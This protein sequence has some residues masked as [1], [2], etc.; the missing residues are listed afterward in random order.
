MRVVEEVRYLGVKSLQGTGQGVS[1]RQPKYPVHYGVLRMYFVRI[2]LVRCHTCPALTMHVRAG[3][4]E[5]T[6]Y[7]DKYPYLV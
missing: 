4:T 6:R 3:S 5:Y 7:V 2:P 1:I